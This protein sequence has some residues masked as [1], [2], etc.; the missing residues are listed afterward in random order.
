MLISG[1]NMKMALCE[2]KWSSDTSSGSPAVGRT[3]PCAEDGVQRDVCWG[4]GVRHGALGRMF[5]RGCTP[6]GRVCSDEGHEAGGGWVQ[7]GDGH[8]V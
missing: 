1:F 8:S 2:W 5:G 6:R 4:D 3:G 7:R